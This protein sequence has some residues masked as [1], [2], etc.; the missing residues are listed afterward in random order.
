MVLI[1]IAC[2]CALAALAVFGLREALH[3][4]WTPGLGWTASREVEGFGGLR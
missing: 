4:R 2:L 1:M 3:I